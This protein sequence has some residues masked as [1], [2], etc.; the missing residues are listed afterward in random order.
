M[1]EDLHVTARLDNTNIDQ[2]KLH[3]HGHFK[4]SKRN[5][6]FHVIMTLI[7][8]MA[9]HLTTDHQTLKLFHAQLIVARIKN[10][11]CN[12]NKYATL[13]TE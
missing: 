1:A 9:I 7:I 2:I 8:P 5:R 11:K 4:K 10:N 3:G 13:Y 6:T 12:L